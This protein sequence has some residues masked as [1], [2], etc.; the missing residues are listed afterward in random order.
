MSEYFV[1]LRSIKPPWIEKRKTRIAVL[2]Y[3]LIFFILMIIISL[4]KERL[5][6]LSCES[7]ATECAVQHLTELFPSKLT[8]MGEMH[9]AFI[10][11]SAVTHI[12]RG[13]CSFP[14]IVMD[15]C[16]FSSF[17][18]SPSTFIQSHIVTPPVTA[19][20]ADDPVRKTSGLGLC[21]HAC[22]RCSGRFSLFFRGHERSC[23]EETTG[24]RVH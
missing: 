11:P 12:L 14:H 24:S 5:T 3:F 2:F 9:A 8:R 6:S 1:P 20:R 10:F 13:S 16:T 19:R 23:G 18:L 22:T 17:H 21:T 7:A 15:S 4:T